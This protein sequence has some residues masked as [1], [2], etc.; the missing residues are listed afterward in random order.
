M[1]ESFAGKTWRRMQSW[2]VANADHVTVVFI[3]SPVAEPVLPNAG[4]LRLWLAEGFL[5]QSRS[6]GVDRFPALHGGVS[7]NVLGGPATF[8]TLARPGENWTTPGAQLDV[9]ITSLLPYAGGTVELEAALYQ[10]S[11]AGPLGTAVQ[12]ITGLAPMM[13][14]PL[15]TAAALAERVS[16]GLDAVL[17]AGG[18]EPVL[19][20]HW[21]MVTA[22]A[23]GNAVR[24]G[25]LAVIGTPA[26]RLDGTPVIE[27]G[28]LQLRTSS[29]VRPLTGVDYLLLWVEC[30]SERDDWRFPEL[31]AL[32]RAA[33]DDLIR[34]YEESFAERRTE[35]IA[36]AWNSPDLTP[37]DRRRV[38]LL[39][40]EELDGLGGLGAVPGADSTLESL[41]PRRLPAPDDDRLTDLT[42]ARLLAG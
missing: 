39:V 2:F 19:G 10:A 20:V 41:A 32:I 23:G 34:G 21:S 22:G 28:R 3:P 36:R 27:G 16:E 33:G 38:A 18:D 6:W 17:A 7:L 8:S 1:T 31:D 40:K 29:G 35:A 15:S 4:Y 12:L 26:D 30:R 37:P 9:R 24:P 25:H 14:P 11:S 42:L 13:G 5:A